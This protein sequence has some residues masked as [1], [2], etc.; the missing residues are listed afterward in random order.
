MRLPTTATDNSQRREG[1]EGGGDK[2]R[3]PNDFEPEP[4]KVMGY[5]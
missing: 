3:I 2:I 5:S 1:R 4:I